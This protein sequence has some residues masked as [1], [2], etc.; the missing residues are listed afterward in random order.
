[1]FG[2]I[3]AAETG[4]PDGARWPRAK[5]HDDAAIVHVTSRELTWRA[6]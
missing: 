5:R 6:V 2:R 3:R 4:D 1:V